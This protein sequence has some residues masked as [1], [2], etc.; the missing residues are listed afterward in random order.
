MLNQPV[1]LCAVCTAVSVAAAVASLAA[2]VMEAS[3]RLYR[4]CVMLCEAEFRECSA[5]S[6]LAEAL[7]QCLQNANRAKV[8][9]DEE[10]CSKGGLHALARRCSECETTIFKWY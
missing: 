9:F 4:A 8:Y 6:E 2:A 3:E 10:I 7:M 1:Y 5:E